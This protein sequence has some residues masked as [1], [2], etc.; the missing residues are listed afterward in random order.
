MAMIKGLHLFDSQGRAAFDPPAMGEIPALLW[1]RI[2]DAAAVVEGNEAAGP[3]LFLGEAELGAVGG[4]HGV[5]LDEMVL[6]DSEFSCNCCD[7]LLGEQDMALPAAA[8]A[9]LPAC[10]F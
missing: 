5:I 4:D 3:V 7:V 1:P 9:T 6:A 10:E 2:V 8:S